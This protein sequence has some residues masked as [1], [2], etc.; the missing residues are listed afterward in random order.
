MRSLV[1]IGIALTAA[2]FSASRPCMAQEAQWRAHIAP[3]LVFASSQ[4]KYGLYQNYL[5]R[6]MDRP[7]FH[8]PALSGGQRAVV[9]APSFQRIM[10]HAMMYEMDGLGAI[11]GNAGMIQRYELAMQIA[12]QGHPEGFRFFP[13]FGGNAEVDY[14]LRTLEIA[15]GADCTARLD[16]RLV[17]GTYGGDRS[18]PA[19]IAQ[20]LADLRAQHGDF[21]YLIG[22]T[23]WHDAEEEFLA[24]GAVSAKTD[25]AMRAHLRTW[26]DMADGIDMTYGLHGF[27]RPDRTF[28][29]AFYRDYVIPTIKSVLSEPPYRDRLL[30]LGAVIGYFNFMT[31]SWLDEDGTRTLRHSFEAAM[32]AQPD[33]IG[34]AEWDELN[35]HTCI[36][37]TI[38]NSLSTQRIIHHYMR[39]MHGQPP[40]PNPG[41]D[42]SIPNLIVSYR[43]ALTLGEE[44]EVELL[45][46]PDGS[47]GRY[48]VIPA[49]LDADGTELLHGE[50]MALD[51]ASLDEQRWTVPTERLAG[52]VLL[53]PSLTVTTTDG[54]TLNYADGLH[55]ITL[56]PTENW[57][58]KWVKLPLRD[59]LLPAEASFS[60][61]PSQ[62]GVGEYALH[63]RIVCDE[64]LATVEV[65]ENEDEIYAV[66]VS[67]AYPD[68][69][70]YMLL[71]VDLRAMNRHELV[72]RLWIDGCDARFHIETD[73]RY[74]FNE[75]NGVRANMWFGRWRRVFFA[76]IPREQVAQGVLHLDFTELRGEIPLRRLSR[77]G[78]YSQWFAPD[79]SVTL[80]DFRRLPEPPPHINA[81]QASFEFTATPRRPYSIFH[82]RAITRSGKLWRSAPIMVAGIGSG[83]PVALPVHSVVQNTVTHV[84]VAESQIPDIVWEFDPGN[85]TLMW[86]EAGVPFC[87]QLGGRAEAVTFVG[88]GESGGMGDP[89]RNGAAYPENFISTAPQWTEVDGAPALRFDGVSN[90]IAFPREVTPRRNAWTLSFEIKPTSPKRQVLWAHH[91]HY[92]GSVTI[93]LEDGELWSTYTDERLH[94]ST[95]RPG[96]RVPLN[97]WS[98][99][100]VSY[101]LATMR[102]RVNGELSEPLP[103]PGPGLY[104]GTSVFGGLGA[105]TEYFEGYL[106]ALRMVHRATLQD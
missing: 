101:D 27:R 6:Y 63:G 80:E 22:I 33:M 93:Y 3:P 76:S 77:H 55:H 71:R 23:T 84:Q 13:L 26:L 106:R 49:L 51:A 9:T 48:T 18:D 36:E 32:E 61:T 105:G 102:F 72:G 39:T 70:E 60:L 47:T 14:K 8:D 54:R 24:N 41:D 87:G 94:T 62:S 35:E 1:A 30:R 96:L 79:I 92:V 69:D 89:F 78:L 100:E 50:P 16:G 83:Q 67:N 17:F 59:L 19:A 86:T 74:F 90:Y 75:G 65:L 98:S 2:F 68:R 43:K 40:A 28:D 85:G 88:G 34:M 103:A 5:H 29:V 56:R 4:L 12:N 81:P 42:P 82:V 91:G 21:V 37:P 15:E 58:Y 25:A 104:L 95:Q 38:T 73:G 99:V 44:L 11:I 46:V 20:M 57:D 52:Q 10:E 64:P 97:E 45:N 53:R 66:D 7:L 31:G